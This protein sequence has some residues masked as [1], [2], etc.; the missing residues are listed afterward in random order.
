M[1]TLKTLY[2]NHCSGR[3]VSHTCLSICE[4]MR[5]PDLDVRLL[6]P[7]SV[8]GGRRGFTRDAIHPWLKGLAYRVKG[9]GWTR[10]RAQGMYLQWLQP[11]DVAYLWPGV[12]VKTYEAVKARGH[13]LVMER[14]NTHRATAR[15]ILEHAY[16]R[17]GLPPQHNITDADLEEER[18]KL[19]LCDYVFCPSPLV[20]K[21]VLDDGVPPERVLESSYGWDPSRFSGTHRALEPVDGLTVL[22]VGTIC[23]RKGAHLLLDAWAKASVPGRLLLA[24]RMTDEIAAL[25][26]DHLA[27]PDVQHLGHC[28]DM[29]AVFRSADVFAFPTLEEGSPLVSYEAMGNGL[30]MLVS[31]MGAGAIV[32]DEQEGLVRPAYDTDAWVAALQ[33][34]AQDHDFCAELGER[35]K[36]RANAFTWQHV[37]KQRQGRLTEALCTAV[38]SRVLANE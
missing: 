16:A 23:I 21:S 1:I 33:R 13:V 26:G 7:A 30:A 12:P 14:I 9:D 35:S 32:R 38:S 10:S 22:F 18:A 25:C 34:L 2:P 31:P 19:A 15:P 37:G 17:V 6:V 36:H 29:G 28:D 20:A 24:G 3:G 27:R 5:G 4:H 8:R 11:G